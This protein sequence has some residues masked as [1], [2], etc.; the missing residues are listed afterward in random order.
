MRREKCF[1]GAKRLLKA[2][3]SPA[4]PPVLPAET[5]E[6][7]SRSATDYY[8]IVIGRQKRAMVRNDR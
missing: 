5:S 6:N 8:P 7:R 4:P 1:R 2:N 3:P